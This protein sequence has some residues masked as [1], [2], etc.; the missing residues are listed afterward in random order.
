MCPTPY[1]APCW[2]VQDLP[3]L[4]DGGEP[5]EEVLNVEEEFRLDEIMSEDV[6]QLYR[7]EERLRQ[8]RAGRDRTYLRLVVQL[9]N[10]TCG[11][12]CMQPS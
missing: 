6:K 12:L 5:E 11:N 1:R 8:V 2:V 9:N 3:A 7:K 4:V 10:G